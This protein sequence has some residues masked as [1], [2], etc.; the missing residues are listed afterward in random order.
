MNLQALWLC[1][2][3]LAIILPFGVTAVDRRHRLLVD[4]SSGWLMGKQMMLDGVP[5]FTYFGV[6]YAEPPVGPK[7]F[8]PP[9]PKSRMN[10]I[11][12]ATEFGPICP[13][14]TSSLDFPFKNPHHIMKEDC[15]SLNIYVPLYA[16]KSRPVAVM[17]WIHGGGYFSGSGN[18]YN[19]SILSAVGEVIV[20]TVNYR[21]GALGFLSTEDDSAVGNYGLWDQFLAL[22]WVQQNIYEFGGDPN[23]V[24]LFGQSSGGASV[25][26]HAMSPV[27]Q[28]TFHR[29]ISQSGSALAPWAIHEDA[30]SQARKLADRLGCRTP[31]NL[32]LMDNQM[33]V[34]CLQKKEFKDIVAN[35]DIG[36]PG[37][38]FQ[39]AWGPVV[40]GNFL[41][42]HPETFFSKPE[43]PM[44]KAMAEKDVL[45][46]VNSQDGAVLFQL[47]ITPHLRS[48][49]LN[50]TKNGISEHVYEKK[51]IS[52]I[53][54]NSFEGKDENVKKAILH[55]YT[56]WVEPK[57]D[58]ERVKSLIDFLSDQH[59]IAGS[60][61]FSKEHFNASRSLESGRGQGTTFLYL[62]DHIPSWLNG[63]YWTDG[64]DH[65]HE[66]PFVFGLP[67]VPGFQKTVTP[68]ER[69]LSLAMINYWANFAKT[70]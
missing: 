30:L 6:P 54:E 59:F 27:S 66:L 34:A 50:P 55:Q 25:Q 44:Y 33:L 43:S 12:N 56:N 3:V 47:V 45:A 57:N 16:S 46:G 49:G 14:N 37:P 61:L 15:L 18:L 65:F 69:L 21:L 62:F 8:R 38:T 51:L 39:L 42:Y 20:V 60:V 31:S 5:V 17:V 11:F 32:D 28:R 35:Q 64:S 63:S 67:M 9:V 29:L 52:P 26:L 48:M 70:G 13:Q 36:E 24:T 1:T 10:Q 2:C 58:N 53:V 22:E 68:E 19:A 7:R 4:T 40:D 23:R 41:P